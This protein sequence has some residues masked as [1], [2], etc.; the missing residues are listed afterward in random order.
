MGYQKKPDA[1]HGYL[2]ISEAIIHSLQNLNKKPNLRTGIPRYRLAKWVVLQFS[3]WS[4]LKSCAM[5]DFLRLDVGSVDKEL[6][7]PISELESGVI[8]YYSWCCWWYIKLQSF[9]R[10]FRWLAELNHPPSI[11]LQTISEKILWQDAVPREWHSQRFAATTWIFPVTS[12]NSS[13]LRLGVKKKTGKLWA[14][15]PNSSQ[16]SISISQTWA[17]PAV[18]H[19]F[20]PKFRATVAKVAV[21]LEERPGT[22][23]LRLAEKVYHKNVDVLCLLHFLLKGIFHSHARLLELLPCLYLTS[24]SS[25]YDHHCHPWS[26]WVIIVENFPLASNQLH[27]ETKPQCTGQRR[28]IMQCLW[29]LLGLSHHQTLKK[30]GASSKGVWL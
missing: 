22:E 29:P 19:S 5:S 21:D 9:H 17:S 24:P 26:S 8:V 4:H 23:D 28:P 1:T 20:R 3:G 10:P 15:H 18:D 16:L 25:S 2:Y 12:V 30:S 7:I 27:P 6:S 11:V 14:M 13:R